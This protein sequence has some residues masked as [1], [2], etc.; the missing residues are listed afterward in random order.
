MALTG[1]LPAVEKYS[2]VGLDDYLEK[3][4]SINNL[5]NKINRLIVK[6]YNISINKK[7]ILIKEEM[8]MDQQHTQELAGAILPG[9]M[10]FIG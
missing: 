8:P 5:Y 9:C 7:D 6:S 10:P 1:N 4:Y 3:P 2:A